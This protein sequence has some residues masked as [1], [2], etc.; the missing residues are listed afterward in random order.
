M[1]LALLLACARPDPVDRWLACTDLD[2]RSAALDAALEQDAPAV[3]ARVVAEPD[4]LAQIALVTELGSRD[5]ALLADLCPQLS[6]TAGR[7]CLRLTERPHLGQATPPPSAPDPTRG[8]RP[9]G[10]PAG[11]LL[12]VPVRAPA[13]ADPIAQAQAQAAC[14]QDLAC[15]HTRARRA[16]EQAQPAQAEAACSLLPAPDGSRDECRFRAAERVVAARGV[17]GLPMAVDLCVSSRFA[18]DCLAHLVGL[19][20]PPSV[21]ADKVDPGAVARAAEVAAQIEAAWGEGPAASQAVDLMW[22]GWVATAFEPVP[23]A[24]L[25]PVRGDLLDH[26]PPRAEAH[27]RAAAALRWVVEHPGQDV[28]ALARALEEALARRGPVAADAPA[29][30]VVPPVSTVSLWPSDLPGEEQIPATW[31]R[32]TLRRPTSSDPTQDTILAV[33]SAIG[34]APG[35]VAPRALFRLLADPE[36]P[37]LHRWAAALALGTRSPQGLQQW[38]ARNPDGPP[39]ILARA[40]ATRSS[41]RGPPRTPARGPPV[42][43]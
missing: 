14:Q 32:G 9:G 34:Q 40:Q 43:P 30:A 38:A 6:P 22:S 8:Q 13:P 7:R 31:G 23:G 18:A 27:V 2:C 37:A 42:P 35:E 4:P 17:G 41:P 3:R 36:A 15:L 1:L 39:L 16:A 19:V 12:A 5:P 25:G 20:T 33:I 26:L 11:D 29:L 24:P 21:P 10:G 28:S